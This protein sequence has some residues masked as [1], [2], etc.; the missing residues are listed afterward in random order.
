[1]PHGAERIFS[2]EAFNNAVYEGHADRGDV[3]LFVHGKILRK[4]SVTLEPVGG[5]GRLR[6]SR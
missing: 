1:M 6:A 3:L 5:S 2:A 4:Y